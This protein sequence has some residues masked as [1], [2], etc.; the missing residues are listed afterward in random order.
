MG[1]NL[2]IAAHIALSRIWEL[3]Y[4]GGFHLEKE[5]GGNNNNNNNNN[6]TFLM[7]ITLFMQV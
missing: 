3:S 6:N 1:K 7:K 5:T 2:L 4:S